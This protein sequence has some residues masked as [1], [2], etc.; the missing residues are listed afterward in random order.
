MNK[1]LS[2][3]LALLFACILLVFTSCIFMQHNP[4]PREVIDPTCDTI[5]YTEYYCKH[6]DIS[7]PA[8]FT[9]AKNH[10]FGSTVTIS[11]A[12]CTKHGVYES[13]CADCGNAFRY[14]VEPKGHS[15]VEISNDGTTVAYECGTCHD[16][17]NIAHDER[18]EDY[19]GCVEIFDVAPT[20]TF[21]VVSSGNEVSVRENIKIIDSYFESTEYENDV[22]VARDFALHNNGDG[23]WTV[24]VIGEYDYNVTYLATLSGE[25]KFADYKGKELSFTVMDDPDH[26][27]EYSYREGVVFLSTLEKENPGYYPYEVTSDKL[28]GYLCLT[29]HKIDDI[30]N[31]QLL[32]IGDVEA[33][34]DIN[35]ETECYFGIVNGIFEMNEAEWMIV[36][37][38]PELSTI[39]E[40][41]DIAL[42]EDINLEGVDV[43]TE[44]LKADVIAELYS[45][46]PFIEFLSAVNV[47]ADK[48]LASKGYYSPELLDTQTF[49]NSVS[50]EPTVDIENNTLCVELSGVI[51]LSIKDA[52][53]N[54]IG[55]L[56]I[57]FSFDIESQF[58]ADINY[59]IDV[60]KET[61]L[62]KFDFA[63]TQ[64]DKI[65]FNFGVAINAENITNDTKYVKNANTG[66]VHLACCVEVVRAAESSVFESVSNEYVESAE[67]KCAHCKPEGGESI[68][69]DFKGFYVDTLYCSDW[70]VVA[71]GIEKLTRFENGSTGVEID[72]ASIEI[73]I[74]GPVSVNFDFGLAF[75]I[76]AS[77]VMNYSC[78]YT[79][80]SVYGM[81]LKHDYVQSYKQVGQGSLT[82]SEVNILGTSETRLGLIVDANVNISG[83]EKWIRA[84]VIAEVGTYAELS[85]VLG[86]E[87]S[88]VG[89]YLE[90]GIY[91]DLDAYYKL[92]NRNGSIN[93][94]EIK[95]PMQKYGYERLYFAYEVYYD[96]I[97]I[98]ASFDIE[99][100]DLL[101][102]RYYDLVNMTVKSDELFLNEAS[103]YNISITFK[104]GTNCEIKNGAIVYKEHAPEFFRDTLIIT[105]TG[106]DDWD[107]YREGNA[108]YYLGVYE[109]DFEFDTGRHEWNDATCKETMVCKNCGYT[110]NKLGEHRESEW[111]I[112]KEM[113]REE[114]GKRHK[115]CTVCG[116]VLREEIIEIAS[117]GLL[118][119]I[120]SDKQ[121]YTLAGMGSCTDV[122]VVIPS[123]HNNLPVTTIGNSA[124][125]GNTNVKRVV[126]PDTVT[127]IDASAFYGCSN[128]ETIVLPDSL[129]KIMRY[130]FYG[131]VS[132]E[133]I[134]IPE[135][136]TFIGE[137]VFNSCN[138]LICNEYLGAYYLG[139]DS[140]PY[141]YLVRALNEEVTSIVI[142]NNTKFVD[143]YAF[144][145]CK[146]LTFNQYDNAYYIGS[147]NNPYLFLFSAKATNIGSSQIHPETKY[148]RGGAFENCA[149]MQSIVIPKSVVSMGY[150]VFDGC[151]TRFKIYCQATSKPEGWDDS[152]NIYYVE[153]RIY[154]GTTGSYRT[155]YE[156][157]NFGV[158][159]GSK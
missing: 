3:K 108:I 24:S 19:T 5:G 60:W 23:T 128:L 111:I 21:R 129:Q 1:L 48:Y 9:P 8:D 121:G 57:D 56:T 144:N 136:V 16:V 51:T 4:V 100:N 96:F 118:F 97:E 47:S 27:N 59:K 109:V 20:F 25:L 84:G 34:S 38:E 55:T 86:S 45:S 155:W 93:I 130:A 110:E 41:F 99:A 63:I 105:V 114:E 123:T 69:D 89:A 53:E 125:N 71:S 147:E 131:C 72:V 22:D 116:F 119:N 107:Q 39:F 158:Y 81:R 127:L 83:F 143:I 17:I 7:Y 148:I 50:I 87:Q 88:Y 54:E 113:T 11:E 67:K 43:N 126:V 150:C 44:Q 49:L 135:S 62:E 101:A 137:R 102:V 61:K 74:L 68:G 95:R 77:A 13:V 36:L 70:E 92:V 120:N 52:N 122:E 149:N 106:N 35:T 58:K 139:N 10:S 115:E 30:S 157:K 94:T 146:S 91:L 117:E 18:I 75:S 33:L 37:A 26:E 153:H 140:N 103:G 104:D 76:D 79:Q 154:I 12:N 46:K 65:S 2:A 40:S 32:C 90:A 15:Y 85:G 134:N 82:H 31:G 6:C 141:L 42:N 159:W 133:N 64:N 73:P 29:V 151:K 152:W 156:A 124:F 112:D 66:E 142:H 28:S 14:T 138:A 80:S 98:K 78:E 145:I 132:L